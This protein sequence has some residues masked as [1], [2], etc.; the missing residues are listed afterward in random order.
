MAETMLPAAPVITNT[1]SGVSDRSGPPSAA[2]TSEARATLQRC[3]STVDRPRRAPGS[4]SVSASRH[5]AI[6]RC[7]V[8]RTEVDRFDQRVDAL[9]CVGLGEAGHSPTHRS[10]CAGWAVPVMPAEAGGT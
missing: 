9:M 5:S 10:T 2:G 6:A 7:V 3:P 8:T 4:W 1:L